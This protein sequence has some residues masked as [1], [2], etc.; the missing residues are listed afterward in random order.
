MMASWLFPVIPAAP[1]TFR[2]FA[3][4]GV[5]RVE[6]LLNWYLKVAE[7]RCVGRVVQL[8]AVLIPRVRVLSRKLK[9]FGASVRDDC[10]AKLPNS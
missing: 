7:N 2:R 8:I 3:K 6:S 4:K 1:A 9:I 5:V 10:I